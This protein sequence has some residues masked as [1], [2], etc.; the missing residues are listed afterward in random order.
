MFA[1]VAQTG[2]L[3]LASQDKQLY[4]NEETKEMI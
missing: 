1:E 4:T 3:G 2:L